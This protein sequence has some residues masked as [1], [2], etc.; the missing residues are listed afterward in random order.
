ML[1]V[2]K[3]KIDNNTKI[4]GEFNFPHSAMDRS[5][6]QTINKENDDALDKIALTFIEDSIWK[7]HNAH[8]SQAHMESSPG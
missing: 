5:S 3:E 1:T 7:Q 4:V 6:R 8:S 2:I